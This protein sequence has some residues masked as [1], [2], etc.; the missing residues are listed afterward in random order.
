M[1][2]S[3]GAATA[4]GLAPLISHIKKVRVQVQKHW[5]NIA[6]GVYS[7][8]SLF[9]LLTTGKTV[10]IKSQTLQFFVFNEYFFHPYS[11]DIAVY[12]LF[13]DNNVPHHFGTKTWY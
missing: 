2:E 1:G 11:T 9:V 4:D 13:H 10:W 3:S 7:N 8:M 5:S 6:R 12:F